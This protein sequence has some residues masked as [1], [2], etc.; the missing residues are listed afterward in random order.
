MKRKILIDELYPFRTHSVCTTGVSNWD[1]LWDEV[2]TGKDIRGQI[3]DG[4]RSEAFQVRGTPFP[5]P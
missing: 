1:I 3:G 2:W 4:V 5:R